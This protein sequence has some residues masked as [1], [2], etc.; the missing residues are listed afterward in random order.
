MENLFWNSA[1]AHLYAH[2]QRA[3]FDQVT[4]LEIRG[5]EYSIKALTCTAKGVFLKKKKWVT[6]TGEAFFDW[7]SEKIKI[8][9]GVQIH[10]HPMEADLFLWDDYDGD[11]PVSIDAKNM[12]LM[13]SVFVFTQSFDEQLPV[14]DLG[15]LSPGER[16]DDRKPEPP[17]PGVFDPNNELVQ[18]AVKEA[19][20][21]KP[22]PGA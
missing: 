8:P 2:L 14:P 21:V 9:P 16:A 17:K 20:K 3:A 22:P 1:L 12:K 11:I 10:T 7:H 18:Q 6:Y 15:L 5:K 19:G 13:R 4:N